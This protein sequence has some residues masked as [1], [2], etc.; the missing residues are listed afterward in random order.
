MDSFLYPL[1]FLPLYKQKV[2]GG[3][4]IKALG[5]DYDP[6]PNC[7]EL[8]A[9]SGVEGNESVVEN[10]FLAILDHNHLLHFVS[11]GQVFAVLLFLMVVHAEGNTLAY[12]AH[13]L[14][15][16]HFHGNLTYLPV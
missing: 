16:K 15:A 9:L 5:F 2:W 11:G 3:N 6:L 8:W 14:F 7:G 13:D 1:K 4:R 10:G 12:S